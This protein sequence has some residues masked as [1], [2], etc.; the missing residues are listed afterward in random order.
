MRHVA[1][2]YSYSRSCVYPL[3]FATIRFFC[4]NMD[5]LMTVSPSYALRLVTGW[6]LAASVFLF[7][8]TLYADAGDGFEVG[9]YV[10]SPSLTLTG[11]YTSNLYR[12]YYEKQVG[13]KW[14]PN[15]TTAVPFLEVTPKLRITTPKTQF[16]DLNLDAA[17][18][19]TQYFGNSRV[20]K[21]SGIPA[22]IRGSAALHAHEWVTLTLSEMFIRTR[23]PLGSLGAATSIRYMN[24]AGL[25]FSLHPDKK[26]FQTDLAYHHVWAY[27]ELIHGNRRQEH[28]GSITNR[29]TFLPGM[30]AHLN[31]HLD[32]VD[33]THPYDKNK[34]STRVREYMDL[35]SH[36]NHLQL[37]L[38]T[39]ISAPL[40]KNAMGSF[41]VG[42]GNSFQ[43]YD[44]YNNAIAK[45]SIA[46]KLNDGETP[47]TLVIA[48]QRDFSETNL[49]QHMSFDKIA[50]DY[51]QG[52]FSNRLKWFAQISL[53]FRRHHGV[54]TMD[55]DAPL[56][57]TFPTPVPGK[58]YPKLSRI[59]LDDPLDDILLLSIFGIGYDI[60]KWLNLDLQYRFYGNFVNDSV[61]IHR[62]VHTPKM[63]GYVPAYRL[64]RSFNEHIISGNVTVRY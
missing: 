40:S 51:R 11:R 42:Y 45:A 19:W 7:S 14:I 61:Y 48:Y 36:I 9:P 35:Y 41:L 4:T 37:R 57:T 12:Q 10:I 50:V 25:T 55:I 30:S 27:S 15:P 58:P 56:P 16:L 34:T 33:Y 5:A 46:W 1:L 18:S 62:H 63:T 2:R 6:L 31:A 8:P 24:D 20:S 3:E 38:F 54:P 13:T 64:P 29:W 17:V 49:G 32:Y 26:V 52:A 28:K 47:G 59:G 23:T 53:S 21:Q 22:T 39:G 43:Q 44:G 60:T